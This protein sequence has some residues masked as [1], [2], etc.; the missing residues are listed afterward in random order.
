M[1]WLDPRDLVDAHLWHESV[2]GLWA[3]IDEAGR[4]PLAGPV[5][6]ACVVLPPEPLPAC[7]DCLNDSKK[8]SEEVRP[9]LAVSI[10][11]VALGWGVGVVSHEEIDSINV[12]QATF[13]AMKIAY[14]QMNL[15]VDCVFVDGNQLPDLPCMTHSIIKG[16]SKVA[17]IAAASVLAKVERDRLMIKADEVYPEYGF[18]WHKGYGTTMHREALSLLGACPIHRQSFITRLELLSLGEQERGVLSEILRILRS[19]ESC[20]QRHTFSLEATTKIPSAGHRLLQQHLH[21][22]AKEK[23][24]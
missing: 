7:L 1:Q 8:I 14:D 16:D 21:C 5:V 3:G 22:L 6:A 4:G 2:P 12:L 15:D 9:R 23:G 10:R 24:R 18:R 17:S 13:K 11:E 20:E 19:M